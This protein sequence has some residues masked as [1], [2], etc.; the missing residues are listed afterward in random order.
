MGNVSSHYPGNSILHPI[1]NDASFE[2]VTYSFDKYNNLIQ[3]INDNSQYNTE[4]VYSTLDDY[5]TNYYI[6]NKNKSSNYYESIDKKKNLKISQKNDND[7]FFPYRDDYNTYWTGFY[8]TNPNIKVFTNY[9]GRFLQKSRN[10]I[11]IIQ[12]FMKDTYFEIGKINQK[13]LEKLLNNMEQQ[14]S[15]LQHHDAVTGTCKKRVLTGYIEDSYKVLKQFQKQLEKL[16]YLKTEKNTIYPVFCQIK[17]EKQSYCKLPE[18]EK[19]TYLLNIL[20]FQFNDKKNRII[21]I[22]ISQQLSEILQNYQIYDL[23]N[24]LIKGEIHQYKFLTLQTKI[25]NLENFTGELILEISVPNIKNNNFFYTDS[26]GLFRIK[27]QINKQQKY[28]Q[29]FD[30]GNKIPGNFYPITR[31]LTINDTNSRLTVFTDRTQGASS[32]KNGTIQL[33]IYRQ[34]PKDDGKGIGEKLVDSNSYQ[35]N[36]YLLFNFTQNQE[37]N[38]QQK[39]DQKYEI[40]SYQLSHQ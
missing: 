27:R 37:R 29:H 35:F 26:N 1:G 9:I 36:H 39:Q 8:S 33:N 3:K 10:L 21:K 40:L 7:D 25:P 13:D 38:F 6:Y 30:I 12:I 14:V 22:Q 2:N 15:I 34:T 5:F 17:P 16:F 24:N 32:L 23:N 4:I 11:N 31:F 18:M 19:E 28:Q 20:N